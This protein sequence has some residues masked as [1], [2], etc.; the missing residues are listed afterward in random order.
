MVVIMTDLYPVSPGL[1]THITEVSA[2]VV[3]DLLAS[4]DVPARHQHHPPPHVDPDGVGVAVTVE[5][6]GDGCVETLSNLFC[7]DL[8]KTSN[9]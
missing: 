8:K 5:V 6:A 3:S 4:P 7:T 2:V 1:S 9:E